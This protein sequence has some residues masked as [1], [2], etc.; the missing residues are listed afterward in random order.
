MEAMRSTWTDSR[1]DD[2]N[3]RVS[4]ISNEVRE[5][6][7][8]VRELRGEFRA[9]RRTLMQIGG[10]LIGTLVVGMLGLIA[11]QL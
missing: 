4:G 5:L 2:L 9:L 7:K 8:D 11:T 3:G 6:R 1:L 10:G